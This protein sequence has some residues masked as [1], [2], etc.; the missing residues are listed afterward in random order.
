MLTKQTKSGETA[1]RPEAAETIMRMNNRQSICYALLNEMAEL[2]W[3]V[4]TIYDSRRLL[5]YRLRFLA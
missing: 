4:Y 1:P 2:R 3:F 5:R